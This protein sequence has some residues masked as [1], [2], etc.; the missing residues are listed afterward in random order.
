MK[1]SHLLKPRFT[2]ILITLLITLQMSACSTEESSTATTPPPVVGHAANISGVNS[3]SVTEDIDPDGD[4]LLEASGKLNITDSDAGEA[5]FVVTPANGN[6]GNLTI[7][8]DG[9]W[10]YAADNSQAAIQNLASGASLTDSLTVSSV[11][12]T[13]HTVVITIIGADEASTA[14]NVSLSWVA[15]SEREDSTPISLSEIAGYKIYY[16]TTPGQYTNSVDINDGIAEG[17]TF[18][19]LPLGTYFFV[20]TTYDAEGRESQ[21]SPEVTKVI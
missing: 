13:T 20:V 5:V 16:G 9:N 4:N 6:Y 21:Y 17:Y 10:N 15:P 18:K 19:A 7:N 11:D 8:T 14:A 2:S 3:A 12:G 1:I